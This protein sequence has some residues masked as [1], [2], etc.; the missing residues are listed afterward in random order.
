MARPTTVATDRDEERAELISVVLTTFLEE[1]GYASAVDQAR[2][3]FTH[4]TPG[5][6]GA[7]ETSLQF[8][9]S[10]VHDPRGFLQGPRSL[11]T[12][13][14]DRLPMALRAMK[15]GRCGVPRMPRADSSDQPRWSPRLR[16]YGQVLATSATALS[17]RIV[18]FLGNA[19]QLGCVF[20]VFF[21][22]E[23]SS[24]SKSRR[25]FDSLVA[26]RKQVGDALSFA[27]SED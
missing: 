5:T 23:T 11:S 15:C 25:D 4:T 24:T 19:D 14:R 6:N 26:L 13:V 12:L 17:I 20:P 3:L 27:A 2:K 9:R 8:T 10:G 16:A 1:E 7:N 21:E 22:R 18:D